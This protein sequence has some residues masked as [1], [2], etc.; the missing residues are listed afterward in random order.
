MLLEWNKK[1]HAQQQQD[2]QP[3]AAFVPQSAPALARK[4]LLGMQPHPQFV[5]AVD[6]QPPPDDQEGVIDLLSMKSHQLLDLPSPPPF[7][8]QTLQKSAPQSTS[9][10]DLRPL[11]KGP[12]V[13]S[14]QGGHVSG[15][16]PAYGGMTIS[17]P[18]YA[19]GG[20]AVLELL[21]TP[22][23]KPPGDQCEE[24]QAELKSE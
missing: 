11:F 13:V 7:M 21:Q 23:V 5:Y 4:G 17:A 14:A 9:H 1:F 18:G 22:G 15:M 8:G 24:Q 3:T 19:P 20:Q 12:P 10:R 2:V 16:L 6:Q